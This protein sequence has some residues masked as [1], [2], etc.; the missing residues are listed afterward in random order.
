MILTL[1]E[2][3]YRNAAILTSGQRGGD[4]RGGSFPAP[5]HSI[6]HLD[7]K[8]VDATRFRFLSGGLIALRPATHTE[9][10]NAPGDT[11]GD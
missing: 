6:D 9:I 10:A 7:N 8:T 5:C 2:I 3:S 1:Q 4:F 11:G